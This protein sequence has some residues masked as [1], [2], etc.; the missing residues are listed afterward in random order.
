MWFGTMAET[1]AQVILLKLVGGRV[2]IQPREVVGFL[3]SRETYLRVAR[4]VTANRRRPATWRAYDEKIREWGCL[5][6][7]AK[8][9]KSES[10]QRYLCHTAA[11]NA[12]QICHRDTCDCTLTM[13]RSKTNGGKTFIMSDHFY[14]QPENDTCEYQINPDSC[15]ALAVSIRYI[16]RAGR[17]RR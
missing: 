16:S 11:V 5:F 13:R 7:T 1:T 2:V 8:F 15:S 10:P 12:G 6:H 14:V 9:T 3:W 17:R 4:E